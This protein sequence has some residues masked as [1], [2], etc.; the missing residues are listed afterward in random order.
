MGIV[1]VV[2]FSSLHFMGPRVCPLA[3]SGGCFFYRIF[4]IAQKKRTGSYYGSHFCK[5]FILPFRWHFKLFSVDL[6]FIHKE[7]PM[8]LGFGRSP[9]SYSFGHRFQEQNNVPKGPLARF[10]RLCSFGVF[11]RLRNLTK[12]SK[13]HQQARIENA[14]GH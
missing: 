13:P 5:R 3:L 6:F 9:V 1:A 14:P 4:G 7:V 10:C 11:R 12:P 2:L 8:V